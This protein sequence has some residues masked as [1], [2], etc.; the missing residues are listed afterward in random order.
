[1]SLP[2]VC[3]RS[4][5][6]RTSNPTASTARAIGVCGH[7]GCRECI[8][9]CEYYQQDACYDACDGMEGC[10]HEPFKLACG[11]LGCDRQQ[12]CRTCEMKNQELKEGEDIKGDQVY[13]KALLVGVPAS[14]YG[15]QSHAL[16]KNLEDWVE[17]YTDTAQELHSTHCPESPYLELP[18]RTQPTV[19]VSTPIHVPLKI[20]PR[21][22]YP[23]QLSSYCCPVLCSGEC[24]M[25]S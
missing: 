10:T 22:V 16:R 6:G 9:F 12:S 5:V 4:A 8:T 15:I 17:P 20:S 2:R 11:R 7:G 19:I 21:A 1:M 18:L 24:Q 3:E 14:E 25:S 13:V 23:Q